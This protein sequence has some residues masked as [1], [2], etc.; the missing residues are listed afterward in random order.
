MKKLTLATIALTLSAASVSFAGSNL[1]TKQVLG[2]DNNGDAIYGQIN[3]TVKTNTV[4]GFDGNMDAIYGA[5]ET[6]VSTKT[7]AG[8]DGNNDPIYN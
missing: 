2:F 8:F 6:A 1:Q 4:I 5:N 3:G 7:V